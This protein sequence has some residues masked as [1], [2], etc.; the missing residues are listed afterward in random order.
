[1][2]LQALRE[3]AGS[4]ILKYFLMSLLLLAVGGLVLTDAGG[5]F[6]DGVSTN[7][8][9]IVGDE[10]I[11]IVS[12][13]QTLRRHLN[14]SK[15][16]VQMAYQ[17]GYIDQ[18]LNV[19]VQS[20]LLKQAAEDS[21]I[22]ISQH[23][24]AKN[25]SKMLSTLS[26]PGESPSQ[27]FQRLLRNSGLSE[28][29]FLKILERDQTATYMQTAI[30]T[31]FAK[32]PDQLTQDLYAYH[33]EERTIQLVSFPL[34]QVT[35]FEKPTD[36]RLI[37]YYEVSKSQFSVPETRDITIIKVSA[38]KTRQHIT[39]DESQIR[40]VYNDNPIAYT[41]PEKRKI[42]QTVFDTESSAQSAYQNIKDGVSFKIATANTALA[43]I[44]EKE[45]AQ[46]EMMTGLSDV[47][48]AQKEK[49]IIPPIKTN[50]GWSVLKIN[51]IT[52]AKTQLYEE[53]KESIKSE[54]VENELADRL[55]LIADQLDDA[56]AAATPLEELALEIDI[57]IIP[58]IA[59]SRNGND[60]LK[61]YDDA[62]LNI[63]NSAFDLFEGESSSV[64]DT[65]NGDIMAVR[66]D[67]VNPQSIK[68]F[69]E[70]KEE[71]YTKL[72]ETNKQSANKAVTMAFVKEIKENNASDLN[73]FAKRKNKYLQT[74]DELKR[75]SKMPKP[76]SANE[77]HKIFDAE[78]GDIIT[79]NTEN[80]QA[81]VKIMRSKLPNLEQ[82]TAEDLDVISTDT[83]QATLRE[84]LSLFISKERDK[85]GVKI[86][87]TR[88]K[89]AYGTPY[90]TN[91][92][93]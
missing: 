70:V 55:A 11:S 91:E 72:L 43:S 14:E 3:G 28:Q 27:S 88:L 10:S 19:E 32:T 93:P 41:L 90:P 7:D 84:A 39:I 20:H 85:K 23:D 5:F 31:G 57:E 64:F 80:G 30:A 65:T 63:T 33:N 37:N 42:E 2:G 82:A 92:S 8:V 54:L 26:Y 38:E 40:D 9:A 6:T 78:I 75:N 79:L 83:Q 60:A 16:P 15:I 67:H 22:K 89:T 58:H 87:K 21:G 44:A 48:F 17:F 12:F 61:I 46:D 76:L 52:P 49:G 59:I 74:I 77:M 86:N 81:I 24:I 1:M 45:F 18:I 56:L 34:E 69:E 51:D 66:L 13:D 36:E 53:V 73:A 47:A 62:A 4:G 25:I 68:P 71:I 29:R 35:D 50:L